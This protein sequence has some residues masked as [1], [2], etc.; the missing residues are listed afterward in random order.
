MFK[1]VSQYISI[2]NNKLT[3]HFWK[4][5]GIHFLKLIKRKIGIILYLMV[6]K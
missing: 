6:T 2:E 3:T 4:V 5:L 1:Y